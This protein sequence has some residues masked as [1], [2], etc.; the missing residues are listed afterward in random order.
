M[1]NENPTLAR[2]IVAALKRHGIRAKSVKVLPE[3]TCAAILTSGLAKSDPSDAHWIALAHAKSLAQRFA[4]K[5]GLLIVLQ[6][7]EGCFRPLTDKAW[8][9]GMSGLAKTAARE[10]P[11][12]S[13]RIIDIDRDADTERI[14]ADRLAR[15]LMLGGDTL[16]IGLPAD[17]RRL[18]PVLVDVKAN[19]TVSVME[20]ATTWLVPG[21]ARG[22]TAA[23]VIALARKQGGSFALMGR[24]VLTDWPTDIPLTDNVNTLR[25][26]L[27]IACANAGEK[28]K[29]AE[30]S[31]RAS[32]LLAS[33]EVRDTLAAVEKA[34]GKA[35]YIIG[36]I[37]DAASVAAAVEE[38][39][40]AFGNIDGLIHGAGVL[41]DKLIADK[42]RE[43]FDRVFQTK[44]KGLELVLG[45]LSRHELK[46]IALFSSVAARFG[47]AGQVDYSMA[48]EVLNRVAW[49]LKAARPA[50]RILSLN[51]G[52]WDGGMVTPSLRAK[53]EMAGISLI[54]I[55]T[56][57]ELFADLVFGVDVGLELC[58]GSRLPKPE[59]G[60]GHAA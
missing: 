44:V 23:C 55:N 52:P 29:P 19:S 60:A 40:M 51:W 54:P 47:N 34:G 13:V 35:L 38:A 3:N 43:Q 31:R 10:W 58:I 59:D 41:A 46:S 53:F 14:V 25:E 9:G 16:E 21:G 50:A 24:S 4:K 57:A 17:G 30:I 48:N 33:Q 42:T 6:D 20:P 37:T 26:A 36:D 11:K 8:W 7:T 1:T 56:G 45:V 39:E 15:E 27:A 2:S 22:V 49:S 5:G 12:A 28:P 18:A 32:S